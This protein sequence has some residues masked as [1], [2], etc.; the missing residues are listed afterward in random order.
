M[1]QLSSS[2]AQGTGQY[3]QTGL[4]QTLIR[5][6]VYA[7]RLNV[8]M[9][10]LGVMFSYVQPECINLKSNHW[11]QFGY[12]HAQRH[13]SMYLLMFQLPGSMRFPIPVSSMHVHHSL[14]NEAPVVIF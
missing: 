5:G 7:F 13:I 11:F 9:T 2:G 14:N 3:D 12:L 4:E 1:L 10:C 6:Q 8:G